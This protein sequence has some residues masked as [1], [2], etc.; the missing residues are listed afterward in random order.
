[1]KKIIH[2]DMDA[3][4]AAIEIRE[5]PWLKGKCVVVGGPPNSRGV[6]STCSY[7]ARKFGVHSGMSSYQ[8]WNICRKLFFCIR[9]LNC[10]SMSHSR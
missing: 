1:M 4:F 10:I 5:Q 3:F 8:A 6:V 9:I 2:I 7:E